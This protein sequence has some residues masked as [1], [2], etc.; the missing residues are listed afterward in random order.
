MIFSFC[1][2]VWK[3]EF[4]GI[5]NETV[6]LKKNANLDLCEAIK[7]GKKKDLH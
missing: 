7:G 5:L 1:E 6:K 3:S 2:S 4:L